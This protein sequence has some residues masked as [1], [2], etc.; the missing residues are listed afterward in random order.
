MTK[1]YQET[2]I[3]LVVVVALIWLTLQFIYIPMLQEVKVVK[4]SLGQNRERNV[5]IQELAAKPDFF[6]DLF[7][8]IETYHREVKSM[9]PKEIKLSGLLRELSLLARKN[10]IEIISIKP[11]DTQNIQD[12]QTLESN[13][14]KSDIKIICLSSFE[15]LGR[16]IESVENNNLTIMAIKDV[17]VSLEGGGEDEESGGNPSKLKGNLT[18][19]AY[20]KGG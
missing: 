3:A 18:I 7:T 16:Y 8:K 14:I 1:L 11:M 10:H 20:Y 6:T 13:F 2:I 12:E 9:L 15:D 5:R 4:K 17:S 19:E